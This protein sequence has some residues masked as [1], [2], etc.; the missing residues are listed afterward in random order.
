[1][2][3]VNSQLTNLNSHLC[4]GS[5]AAS[6]QDGSTLCPATDPLDVT[7]HNLPERL[8]VRTV[9]GVDV[10]GELRS[11]GSRIAAD[12]AARPTWVCVG[13]T[14]LTDLPSIGQQ[15]WHAALLYQLLSS[16]LGLG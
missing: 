13:G 6:R 5:W 9:I 12:M 2:A 11:Q 14:C 1:M 7:T 10:L 8:L 16:E 4:R 15:V 3:L